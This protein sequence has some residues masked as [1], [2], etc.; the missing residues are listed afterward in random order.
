MQLGVHGESQNDLGWEGPQRSSGFNAP[1][2][3]RVAKY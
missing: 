2:M 1:A 3:G